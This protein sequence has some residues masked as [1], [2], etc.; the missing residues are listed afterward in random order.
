M[1]CIVGAPNTQLIP[2]EISQKWRENR[3]QIILDLFHP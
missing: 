2:P 1:V 3:M